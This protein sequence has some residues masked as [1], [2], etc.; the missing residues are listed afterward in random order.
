VNLI[1]VAIFAASAF[2]QVFDQGVAA[3]HQQSFPAAIGSFEQLIDEGVVR[4]EVFFNLGNA[5]YRNGELAPAIVNYE[6]AWQLDPGVETVGENL[7]RAVGQTERA[8]PRPRPPAWEEGLFFWHARQTAGEGLTVAAV[9]WT[10]GWLLL[11]IRAARPWPYLRGAAWI[12]LAVAG[13]FGASWW[14]KSHPPQVAVAAEARVPVRYGNRAGETVRF[15]LYEGDRVRVEQRA[16]GWARVRTADGERGW[17]EEERLLFV[18]PP[19]TSYRDRARSGGT[20]GR[21]ALEAVGYGSLEGSTDRDA[22]E[23]K[24]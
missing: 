10:L 18:G 15:E 12:A 4:K 6:R 14:I 7:D 16:K 13:V 20:V 5:Y 11:M 1:L 23:V 2:D 8:L 24:R 17:T 19:F 21:E 3:Y 9:S 22:A